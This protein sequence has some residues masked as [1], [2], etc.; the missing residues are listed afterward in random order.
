[1]LSAIIITRDEASSIQR[2]ITSLHFADEVIVVDSGSTDQTM[3]LA[4]QCGAKA[5]SHAWSGYGEQKNFGATQA[6]SEWLLFI[7]ADEEVSPALASA[8]TSLIHSPTAEPSYDFYWLRIITIF[9]RRPLNHL[10]GNNLRLFKKSAGHWNNAPVH[11][12]V[13]AAS[14]QTIKLGNP[15]SGRLIPPLFHHSHRTI[16]A[17]LKKMHHYTTLDAKQMHAAGY[18]RSGRFYKPTSLLPYRVSLRQLVKLLV[19]RR[20]FLDGLAG[21]TWCVLSAYY[22][23]EMGKKYVQQSRLKPAVSAKSSSPTKPLT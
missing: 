7:D 18:H 22:E 11:E 6:S 8:I 14:N 13:V 1:M 2:C 16:H 19:Y 4:K 3:E 9:L 15:Q 10:Y 21:I 17:Y 12:Q 20:G 23:Y 5:Y